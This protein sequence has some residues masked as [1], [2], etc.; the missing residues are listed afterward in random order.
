M[1]TTRPNTPGV[2]LKDFARI[3]RYGLNICVSAVPTNNARNRIRR[4]ARSLPEAAGISAC[5]G[6]AESTF[7]Y[8]VAQAASLRRF[9][10]ARLEQKSRISN[11]RRLAACAT[12]GYFIACH[13]NGNER[14]IT[15]SVY[16]QP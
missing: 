2:V 14:S 12:S 8:E 15:V 9:R 13:A 6:L 7:I 5:I 10:G 4:T 3:G 11:V 1:A 16:S